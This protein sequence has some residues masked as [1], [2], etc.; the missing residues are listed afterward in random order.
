MDE[1]IDSS[2]KETYKWP[3]DMG[4]DLQRYLI[5]REMQITMTVEY[6]LTSVKMGIIKKTEDSKS[7]QAYEEERVLV[8]FWCDCKLVYPCRKQHGDHSKN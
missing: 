6:H 8:H 5:I 2:V 4:K 3:T 1:G 7:Q